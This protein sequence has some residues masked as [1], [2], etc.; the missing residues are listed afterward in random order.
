MP[1]I[2]SN[3]TMSTPLLSLVHGI[4]HNQHLHRAFMENEEV[5]FDLFA[6]PEQSRNLFRE[7][8]DTN[9]LAQIITSELA[10]YAQPGKVMPPPDSGMRS[11]VI[12]LTYNLIN[13]SV[14]WSNFKQG[15]ETNGQESAYV[16]CVFK[17]FNISD[18]AT[19]SS[20]VNLF[21]AGD[22]ASI[23]DHLCQN[24]REELSS[25]V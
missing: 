12:G 25:L 15:V 24:I 4:T 19:Q 22:K 7:S 16:N 13:N 14:I 18:E 20:F 3:K 5:L 23:I 8:T 1:A 10:Q 21:K 9:E 11:A 17:A 2:N 6:V